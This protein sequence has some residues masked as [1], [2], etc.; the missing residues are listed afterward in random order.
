M[1]RTLRHV[2]SSV[3][4]S[5]VSLMPSMRRTQRQTDFSRLQPIVY[6]NFVRSWRRN[7]GRS[8]FA[9]P[10]AARRSRPRSQQEMQIPCHA[11]F[12]AKSRQFRRCTAQILS[13]AFRIST[14][15]MTA[16]K[17]TSTLTLGKRNSPFDR[18]TFALKFNLQFLRRRKMQM[19]LHGEEIPLVLVERVFDDG[20]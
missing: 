17:G 5:Q 2:A 15:Q 12:A 8:F 10:F 18:R 7:R 19:I 16:I 13:G 14:V 11:E 3:E 20:R 9:S 4:I 1:G 6:H